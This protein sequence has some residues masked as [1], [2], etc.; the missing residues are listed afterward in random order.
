MEA[1]LKEMYQDDVVGSPSHYTK[2]LPFEVIDMIKVILNSELCEDMSPYEMFCLGN[3]LKYRMRA[4]YKGSMTT[5][6]EKAMKYEEFM[7]DSKI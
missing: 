4:G 3:I 7:H 6:I 2:H 5:D 1:L